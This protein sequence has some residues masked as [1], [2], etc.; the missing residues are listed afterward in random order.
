MAASPITAPPAISAPSPTSRDYLTVP[1]I[2][3]PG[4]VLDEPGTVPVDVVIRNAYYGA[5]LSDT[6]NL[7]QKLSLTASGR[8]NIANI[9]LNSQLPPDP[10]A[11][12]GGLTG[13]HY[14]EHAN[15]ALGLAYDVTPFTV[16]YGGYTE[17]NAA[18]YA[19][20]TFLRQPGGFLQPGQFHVR[21]SESEADRH[22]HA[23]GRLARHAGR[24]GFQHRNL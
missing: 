10:N 24:P 1:G 21:R 19:R 11:P 22:P 12:G 3:D 5:Y 20:G 7:T 2:P 13:R 17:A 9:A 6:L 18:P 8:F 23:A 16:L 15:P 14:Y 4:Y